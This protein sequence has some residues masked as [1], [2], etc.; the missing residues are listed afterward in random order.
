MIYKI[1]YTKPAFQDLDRVYLE[2]FSS[3]KDEDTS[4]KYIEG[5]MDTIEE[6]KMFPES[7]TPLYFNDILTE[8]RFVIYKS[9]IAF[10]RIEN[11]SIIVERVLYGKS[12]YM[13]TLHLL[14]K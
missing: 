14:D 2:V 5:I 13:K 7:E 9:Y 1:E 3:S 11:G 6:K 4:I 10:Y 12:D 8:Y